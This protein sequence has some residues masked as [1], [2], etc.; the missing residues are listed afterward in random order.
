MY[1]LFQVQKDKSSV[2]EWQNSVIATA[3]VLAHEIGHA[4][5]LA[6]DFDKNGNGMKIPRYDSNGNNC[7]GTNG[8]MDHGPKSDID[9]FSSCSKEDF[10]ATFL[11]LDARNVFCLTCGK[12]FN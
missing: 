6:H 11:D 4:L 3:G 12:I 9:K 8:V 2:T 10:I 1:F 7:K 5:G